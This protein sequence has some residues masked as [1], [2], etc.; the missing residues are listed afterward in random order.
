MGLVQHFSPKA[1]DTTAASFFLA[2]PVSSA[3][4][5][6][7]RGINGPIDPLVTALSNSSDTDVATA[8]ASLRVPT[9][10]WNKTAGQSV[11]DAIVGTDVHMV[12]A[13]TL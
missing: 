1:K 11:H 2:T 13:P 5:K 7:V 12:A 3:N 6:Y 8:N 9:L 10:F 4:I